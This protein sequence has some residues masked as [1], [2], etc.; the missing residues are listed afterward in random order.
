[1]NNENTLDGPHGMNPV[2]D[3][4]GFADGGHEELAEDDLAAC[5]ACHGLGGRE[6][7]SVGTV[8]SVAKAD[9]DFRDLEDGGLVSKGT[10]IGCTTCHD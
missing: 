8:L 2:G 3:N 6:D 7:N 1:M 10:P 9:R 4:T 5:E